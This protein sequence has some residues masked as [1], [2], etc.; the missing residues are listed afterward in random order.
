LLD[1][2]SRA[3]NSK[4]S[5]P[6]LL[7]C[8]CPADEEA[9]AAAGYL[10]LKMIGGMSG[11]FGGGDALCLPDYPEEYV[12]FTE[13][14]AEARGVLI[15][16]SNATLK[17]R[18]ELM[19]I[20]DAISLSNSRADTT[21]AC[22]VIPVHLNSFGFPNESYFKE[23][24]P[25]VIPQEDFRYVSRMLKTCFKRISVHLPLSASEEVL[26][27]QVTAIFHRLP[28]MVG[29]TSSGHEQSG[30]SQSMVG[31]ANSHK[32]SVHDGT[33]SCSTGEDLEAQD[34]SFV[35]PPSSIDT[36]LQQENAVGMSV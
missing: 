36:M 32:K 3:G 9:L 1:F 23:V 34:S 26:S 33:T 31:K 27:A 5:H 6:Q 19:I 29:A 24:L 28:S 14:M 20:A 15:I 17:N 13:L 16:F 7:I 4:P 25:A 12:N 30:K 8:T 35:I 11:V 2:K 18:K 10:T 21:D 22:P